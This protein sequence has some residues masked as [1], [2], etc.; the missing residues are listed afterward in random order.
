MAGVALLV[1]IPGKI[2]FIKEK[3]P[4]TKRRIFFSDT[5]RLFVL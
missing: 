3:L 2:L 4:F 1:V 5:V